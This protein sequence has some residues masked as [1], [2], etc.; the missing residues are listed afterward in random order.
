MNTTQLPLLLRIL[1]KLE[2]PHKLGLLDRFFAKKLATRGICTARTAFG[3]LWKLDFAN[4]THR[5]LLYGDY[6]GPAL[7]KWAQKQLA[8]KANLVVSGAN[9]GQIIASLHPRLSFKHILAFEPNNEAA[10]WLQ[11]CLQLN[12]HIPAR[13]VRAGLGEKK[14]TAKLAQTSCQ[15][16]Q[17]FISQDFGETIPITTL[18]DEWSVQAGN[19][20]L[21]VLDVEGTKSSPSKARSR[22][23]RKASSKPFIWR[24]SLLRT[25]A[26]QLP[27]SKN[28]A[29]APTLWTTMEIL[30]PKKITPSVTVTCLLCPPPNIIA[31][32]K[33][34]LQKQR[35]SPRLRSAFM[36]CQF[37]PLCENFPHHER[38]GKPVNCHPHAVADCRL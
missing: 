15:G 27:F 16:S 7:R 36:T 29:G 30:V 38:C 34:D 37:F 8:P 3:L 35:P 11:F 24:R 32:Q 25:A 20:D 14:T 6:E 5:W 17:S 10:D 22:S 21:W 9:I 23:L 26:R 18:A 28:S 19:I 4:P 13:L 2:F 12:T 33:T 31:H 1:R